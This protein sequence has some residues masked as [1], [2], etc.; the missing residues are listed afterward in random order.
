MGVSVPDS[1]TKPYLPGLDSSHLRDPS[2]EETVEG[3]AWEQEKS[4][5]SPMLTIDF[6]I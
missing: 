4:A 6:S 2:G 1:A 3:W 5:T